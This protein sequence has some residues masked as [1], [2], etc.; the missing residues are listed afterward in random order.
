MS[1]TTYVNNTPSGPVEQVSGTTCLGVVQN[2]FLSYGES[3][4]MDDS[5]PLLFSCGIILSGDCSITPTPTPTISLTPTKTPTQTP[6]R[7][8]RPTPTPSKT[9]R[10]T[11]TPT[12]TMTSTPTMTRTPTKTP[13]P[14]RTSTPT[15]TPTRTST[16]TQT[17]TKTST[18]TVTPTKTATQTPTQTPTLTFSPTPTNTNTQTGTPTPTRTQTPTNTSTPTRTST[19]TPTPS[20]TPSNT[21]T[22]TQTNTPTHTNTPTNTST[23]TQ[24]PTPSITATQT[25]TPT[26]TPT[27][28]ST[29]TPTP[30]P[31]QTQTP[32]QTST[33]TQT[34][35][36][37]PT[38]TQTSTQ[39]QTPTQT[40]TQTSTPTPTQTPFPLGFNPMIWVDFNDTST[41]TFRSGTNYLE[42]ISNKGYWTAMTGFSQN[43]LTA[44]TEI[45]TL[46][47]FTGTAKSGATVSRSWME[48][49][50]QMTGT[51][52]NVFVVCAYD[53]TT[54][55][56]SPVSA[57]NGKPYYGPAPFVAKEQILWNP[58]TVQATNGRYWTSVIEPP[59]DTSDDYQA[60]QVTGNTDWRTPHV[61]QSYI[62]TSAATPD[63]TYFYINTTGYSQDL[64]Y[65]RY[66]QGQPANGNIKLQIINQSGYTSSN[67]DVLGQIGEIVLF[68]KELTISEL[69]QLMQYFQ[70][71]WGIADMFPRPTPTPTRTQ[72][73]TPTQT[74]TPTP[75]PT[76]TRTPTPTGT[77]APTPTPTSF[78]YYYNVDFTNGSCLP[79]YDNQNIQTNIPLTLN[80]WYCYNG[81]G[82]FQV[83]STASAGNYTN[84]TVVGSA[85]GT[86]GTAPC[87]P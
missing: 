24:T 69:D 87:S 51:N 16:P 52:W 56:S 30:T 83:N 34:P 72:T 67:Q 55:S 22:P 57:D 39:T 18:P 2:F 78:R 36:N 65:T 23:S 42:S 74:K 49:N 25:E 54:A 70:Y 4:C 12:K 33:Q 1:C 47:Y 66:I 86:C 82:K 64:V 71:K 40:S 38:Q 10:V 50:I 48:S 75:S 7:T 80:R 3:V 85:Y 35:T 63:L 58:L 29:N 60:L 19:Q 17:P 20:I 45:N 21:Q 37:T 59:Y 53:P 41:M 73:P 32:T 9:P 84:I 26:Q 46:S 11:P 6:T 31:T 79:P 76:T 13:T 14:T 61:L 68:D 43:I 8:S 81:G 62:S 27:E 44:Q 77:L 28:T 5:K 15:Q